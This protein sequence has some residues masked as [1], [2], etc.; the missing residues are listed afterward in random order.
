L[1]NFYLSFIWSKSLDSSEWWLACQK[2]QELSMLFPKQT[3]FLLTGMQKNEWWQACQKALKFLDFGMPKLD[4]KEH[5][6]IYF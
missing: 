1:Q 4:E 2:E 3:Y 6:T 5:Y